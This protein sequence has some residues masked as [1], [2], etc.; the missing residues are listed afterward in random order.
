MTDLHTFVTAPSLPVAGLLVGEPAD[1]DAVGYL[2]PRWSTV[3]RSVRGTKM[4]T[5]PAVFDEF[6][7]A[8]QFPYYF[9]ENKDAFD[10]CMRDLDEFVGAAD[11]YL[12][13]VRDAPALLSAEP[14]ELSWFVDAM[15]FY[16]DHWRGIGPAGGAAGQVPRPFRVVLQAT[17]QESGELTA[18]W[19]R[20]GG[21]L[22]PVTSPGA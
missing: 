2:L 8:F 17:A 14:D 3:G 12:V 16:A 9:G 5:V 7:A 15:A 18:R 4:R 13:V 21:T 1:A 19:S 20:A 11:G 22:T 6:A 10:E